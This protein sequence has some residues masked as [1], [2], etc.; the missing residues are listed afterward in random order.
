MRFYLSSFLCCSLF[1]LSSCETLKLSG[2]LAERTSGSNDGTVADA[3]KEAL[4]IGTTNAVYKLSR[5]GGFRNSPRRKIQL[6]RTLKPVADTLKQIGLGGMVTKFEDAMNTAA[7]KSSAKAIPIFTKALTRMSFADALRILREKG[8][9]A[10][11]YFR[12]KTSSELNAAFRPIIQNE[13]RRNGVYSIYDKIISKYEMLPFKNKPEFDLE[14]YI[15]KKTLDA[16]FTAIADEER[17]IRANPTARTTDLLKKV[18]GSLDKQR[19]F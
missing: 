18:F 9:P 16:L 8:S 6:P 13:M 3:L 1:L 14:S 10:T 19:S 2:V 7:E 5:S 15:A 12:K 4:R 11:D 17:L